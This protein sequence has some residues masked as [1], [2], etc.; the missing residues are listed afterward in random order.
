M[1]RQSPGLLPGQREQPIWWLRIAVVTLGMVGAV[2]AAGLAL[3]RSASEAFSWGVLVLVPTVIGVVAGRR[4]RQDRERTVVGNLNCVRQEAALSAYAGRTQTSDPAV[5][6]DAVKLILN[7]SG[8]A[9]ATAPVVGV[10]AL[11]LAVGLA[12]LAA[13]TSK[14]WAID[15]VLAAAFGVFAIR[16]SIR[17]RARLA[18]LRL[19]EARS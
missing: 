18:A 1:S 16:K 2:T 12:L 6:Q 3:G 17:L 13:F 7:V 5:A 8:D 19:I 10:V 15:A 9:M 11:G 14:W 4:Q